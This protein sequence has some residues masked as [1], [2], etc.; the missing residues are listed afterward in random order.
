MRFLGIL[1]HSIGGRLTINSLFDGIVQNGHVIDIFD[2]LKDEKTYLLELYNANKYDFLVGYD[3]SALRFK[4]LD[5]INIPAINY[6]SDV[7]QNE[8]SGKDWQCYYHLLKDDDNYTFYWDEELYNDKK[9]EIKN[10]FYQPHFVNTQIYKNHGIEPVYDISFAGRLDTDF[11]LHNVLNL[12][13]EFKDKQFAWY[14]I[15]RHFEDAKNRA[16][17]LEDKALLEKN[18]RGFIATENQMADELNKTRI[19]FNFNCQGRSSLNYRTF[20]VMA[21]EKLLISDDRAEAHTL[22]KENESI[23]IH[24]SFDDLIEKIRHY[25][26]NYDEYTRIV[27]NSRKIVEA[28]HSSKTAINNMLGKLAV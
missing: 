10:L 7:M 16:E 20:Q 28:N 13:K 25:L 19:V 18:Y 6:F 26:E 9:N 23:I 2:V 1:P 3:F 14:A 22:F 17:N 5:N 8:H 11:R 4:A 15:E 27:Q 24:R 12:M 21:C